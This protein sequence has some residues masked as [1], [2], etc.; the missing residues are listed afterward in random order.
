M[1]D[2]AEILRHQRPR[3][4][5]AVRLVGAPLRLGRPRID[6][7]IGRR[8]V[9]L[10]HEL[11]LLERQADVGVEAD[12]AVRAEHLHAP[13][14][15]AVLDAGGKLLLVRRRAGQVRAEVLLVVVGVV[16]S[17]QAPLRQALRR[18]ARAAE[19]PV[20]ALVAVAER[21]VDLAD[22]LGG[23]AV[24]RRGRPPC[25]RR[26][27]ARRARSAATSPAPAAACILASKD[28]SL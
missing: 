24:S 17:D 8:L 10:R 6:L 20:D 21:E 4:A 26:S 28:L 22:L 15:L 19:Q 27:P 5:V 12:L 7:R 23:D 3:Q 13:P 14:A 2:V 16:L 18:P 9:D 1:R 25:R 11:L